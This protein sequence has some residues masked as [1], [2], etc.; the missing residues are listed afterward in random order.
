MFVP[1]F[2]RNLLHPFSG[3]T[4]KVGLSEISVHTTAL[5][6]NQVTSEVVSILAAKAL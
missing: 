4:G 6:Q 5:F 3:Q 1:K 2:R